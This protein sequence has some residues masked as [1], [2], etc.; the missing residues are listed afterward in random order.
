MKF[1]VPPQ[2]QEAGERA[3]A[4]ID[5]LTKPVGSLGELEKL[6]VDLA[7]MT[8]QLAT[9]ISPPGIIVFAADHGVAK[10]GV[11]A[12]PQEVT[13]QMVENMVNGGAAIS[14]FGRQI[15]ARFKV[16]DVGVAADI[17]NPKVIHKKVR[18]GTAN[19][20]K[21]E[22]MSAQEAEKA[23]MTGYEEACQFIENGVKCLIVGEVGIGNTTASSA[24]TACLT[25]SDPAA[26]VG[27]G[28]GLSEEKYKR[29]IEVIRQVL[30][31]RKANPGD[32]ID[33]LVKLGGLEIAAMAG[34]MMAA[35]ERRIP[36]LLDGFICT[37]AACI[38]HLLHPRSTDYMILSHY[39]AEPGHKKAMDYLDKTPILQLNLRL[40]EGTG[41]AVAFPILESAVRMVTE[42]ATFESAKVASSR[43]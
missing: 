22:A 29:K 32:A 8:G 14:V 23:V 13:A 30:E 16:V 31:D 15:G 20:L 26:V 40:G 7:E 9:E 11:S 38:A 10:E 42:M 5:T 41:A 27:Y 6:A 25:D 37:A 39:S 35:A 24:I 18:R 3:R 34:A 21:E 43:Q 4:Y 28:T 17:S 36:V 33:V 1:Q 19:F 2:D 12:Y